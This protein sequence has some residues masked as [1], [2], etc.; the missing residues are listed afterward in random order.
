M[1]IVSL[2]AKEILDSNGKSTVEV[3]LKTE[4]GEYVASVPSGVSKGKNEAVAKEAVEAVKNINEVIAVK[5]LGLEVKT[6]QELDD[7][8]LALDGSSD[9]SNL[10]ANG[11]L[12]VSIVCLRGL[13][14]EEGK[15]VWQKI[16]EISGLQ[17]TLPKPLMLCF[18]GG[19]HGASGLDF[20]EFMV[21][22]GR[23]LFKENYELCLAV[24]NEIG[25]IVEEQFGRQGKVIGCEGGFTPLLNG[26]EAALSIMKQ[27][28]KKLGIDGKIALDVAASEFFENNVYDY[29]GEKISNKRML[30]HYQKFV[31]NYPIFLI[32]DPFAKDDI[33]GWQ[34]LKLK[35]KNEKLKIMVVGDDLT[36]TNPK[37]IK[38][39]QEQGICN[40]V[41]IKP[42]QIGTVSETIEAACLVK[43]FGWKI[44]VS[45]RGGETDDNFIADLAVGIGADYIKA[46]APSRPERMVKYQRL[47]EIEI[48]ITNHQETR[49]K[50]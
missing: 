47:L 11:L 1:K 32:E 39:A 17:P 18:E 38:Q 31:A 5:L 40:A 45:H 15:Q 14:G 34:E 35:I 50:Q 26:V 8:L 28:M 46:G 6:Q 20:Q 10:G 19:R 43:K 12:A 44:I 25:K 24:Y 22:T 27:A 30:E 13:A 49:C 3:M 29:M 37:L 48:E 16:A 42:N 33:E 2:Q 41:I 4:K 7:K 21:E 36:A 23:S 9:K